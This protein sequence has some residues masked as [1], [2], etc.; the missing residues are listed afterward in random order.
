MTGLECS[1]TISSS[2]ATFRVQTWVWT[3]PGHGA[4]LGHGL[5]VRLSKITS[6]EGLRLYPRFSAP[7]GTQARHRA[8]PF[9]R[10][11]PAFWSSAGFGCWPGPTHPH[12]TAPRP[13]PSP[14]PGLAVAQNTIH[15]L[16]VHHYLRTGT[17]MAARRRGTQ[18]A[19]QWLGCCLRVLSN[20]KSSEA[21]Q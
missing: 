21:A 8:E 17:V 20:D 3:S 5:I 19:T 16:S 12:S 14:S 15:S 9:V 13:F 6:S 4:T 10:P 2:A 1:R 11:E 18:D 7:A